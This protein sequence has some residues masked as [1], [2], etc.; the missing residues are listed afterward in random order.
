[1]I[2]AIGEKGE[3]ESP[4]FTV[5]KKTSARNLTEVIINQNLFNVTNSEQRLV[6]QFG[7]D[8]VT[9][10]ESDVVDS[11]ALRTFCFASTSVCAVTESEFIHLSNHSFRTA[12]SF[13]FTL[14]QDVELCQF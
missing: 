14:W 3:D 4:E 5:H 1:M 12:G 11:F 6:S 9:V 7:Y 8:K 10:Q 13:N 2:R